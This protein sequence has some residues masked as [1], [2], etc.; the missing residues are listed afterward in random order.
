M[1]PVNA[2]N[3]WRWHGYRNSWVDLDGSKMQ[4]VSG[5]GH[6]G[7]GM[8][9]SSRDQARFGLLF[10]RK[11]RWQGQQILSE[12]WVQMVQKPTEAKAN[13][14]YMWWLSNHLKDEE[15]KGIYLAIGFGG[16]YIMVDEK[17][18]LLVVARWMPKMPQFIQ[19]VVKAIIKK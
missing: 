3:T 4:S 6:F 1:D 12:K 2:S 17:H 10:L 13:Y 5:G 8:F 9:I 14:G 7:G 18:D 11:G 15:L 16:N 19:K